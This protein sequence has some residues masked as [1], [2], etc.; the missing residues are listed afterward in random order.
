[1]LTT[2]Q[3]KTLDELYHNREWANKMEQIGMMP[4]DTGE[5]GEK[6]TGQK[7]RHYIIPGG[8]FELAFIRLDPDELEELRLK[9]LPVASLTANNPSCQICNLAVAS[10]RI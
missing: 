7:I 6:R 9:Y 1:M 3:F 2:N 5:S 8:L 10:K 4:T